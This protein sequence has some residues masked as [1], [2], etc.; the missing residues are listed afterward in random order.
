MGKTQSKRE[1]IIAQ[2]S[3]SGGQ[4]DTANTGS[5]AV[6]R[7]DLIIVTLSAVAICFIACTAIENPKVIS[8][9]K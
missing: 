6:S 3:N 7:L 8:P 5:A 1:V 9:S 4:T 2:A